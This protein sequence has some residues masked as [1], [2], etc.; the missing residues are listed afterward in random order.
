[1]AAQTYQGYFHEGRFIPQEPVA[2][3]DNM[4][5]YVTITGREYLPTKSKAQ[6]QL[7]ALN[8]FVSAIKLIDDELLTDEDFTQLEKSRASFSREVTF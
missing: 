8:R 1:M 2:I 6:R 4:E 5:V 3:P 7:E